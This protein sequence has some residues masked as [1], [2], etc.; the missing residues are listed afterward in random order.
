MS[1]GLAFEMVT[2]KNK[3]LNKIGH[4]SEWYREKLDKK[5]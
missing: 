4:L 3:T 5:K 1:A 2:A